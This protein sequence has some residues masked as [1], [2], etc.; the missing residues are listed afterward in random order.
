MSSIDRLFY[1]PYIKYR[2]WY[3]YIC[4]R[5]YTLPCRN[6]KHFI[7]RIDAEATFKN[8]KI[9]TIGTIVYAPRNARKSAAGVLSSQNNRVLRF[10]EKGFQRP[11]S[12][13]LGNGRKRNYVCLSGQMN[14]G[15]L[16][17]NQ[18]LTIPL[19]KIYGKSKWCDPYIVDTYIHRYA[20][21]LH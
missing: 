5:V 8:I 15:R 13:L 21:P 4:S 16:G 17:L 19:L 12:P 18:H 7:S 14:W 1:I 2:F 10:K 3:T 6:E 9:N 11:T 20:K